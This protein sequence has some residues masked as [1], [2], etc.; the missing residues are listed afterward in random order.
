MKKDTDI[1]NTV[2]QVV[3]Y[4]RI[5]LPPGIMELSPELRESIS[6]GA[7]GEAVEVEEDARVPLLMAVFQMAHKV[8]PEA[9]LKMSTGDRVLIFDHQAE[10]VIRDSD[11]I[12]QFAKNID[13]ESETTGFEELIFDLGK[14]WSENQ[15]D[16]YLQSIEQSLKALNIQKIKTDKAVLLGDAPLLLFL[17]AQHELHGR[18]Q[19]VFYKQSLNS[20]PIK[21][22]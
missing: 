22:S 2:P 19:A 20:K 9:V 3:V 10:P 14:I 7:Q 15:N 21:I 11:I 18:A 17:L 12:D 5:D 16:N 6:L 4:K 13:G 8:S 1:M